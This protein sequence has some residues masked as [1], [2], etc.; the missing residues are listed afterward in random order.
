MFYQGCRNKVSDNAV[1]FIESFHR[2][3]GDKEF[4]CS[5]WCPY[6]KFGHVCDV[7][8]QHPIKI[9]FVGYRDTT[10]DQ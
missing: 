1:N 4:K 2:R 5:S 6:D 7:S 3:C 8:F 9:C 10:R